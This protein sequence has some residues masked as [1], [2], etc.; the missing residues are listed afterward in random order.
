MAEQNIE[1]FFS[2]SKLDE[3]YVRAIN[4]NLIISFN[5]KYLI[6]KN[7]L[8]L[9]P[10]KFINFHIAYL[11]FNR[12]AN[13]NVWSFL[14]GT[15]KGVTIHLIDEGIDTGEI[16]FQ[17]EVNI[18]TSKET[19]SSSYNILIES[20]TD[21]FIS[22]WEYIE[23]FGFQTKKQIGQ[24]TLHYLKDFERIKHLLLPEGYDIVIDEFIRRYNNSKN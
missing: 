17:E 11:P 22:K 10:H 24:G 9:Y 6:R 15:P 20:I 21:L 7:I 13:P 14:D 8:N 23:D 4:P 1:L 18:D 16:I 12:G 5:Y 19:L 3:E 2:N